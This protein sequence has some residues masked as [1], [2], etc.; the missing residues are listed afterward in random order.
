MLRDSL[1]PHARARP[2]PREHHEDDA[3]EQQG[4]DRGQ[5]T[6][7]RFFPRGRRGSGPTHRL[8]QLLR[9][10]R[11]QVRF[12]VTTPRSHLNDCHPRL[13]IGHG[14]G[15]C[16]GL[17]AEKYP[18]SQSGMSTWIDLRVAGMSV[19]WFSATPVGGAVLNTKRYR[20]AACR[21]SGSKDAVGVNGRQHR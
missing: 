1:P 17:F 13:V 20:D 7:V 16:P 8:Q 21:G 6:P 18:S 2:N 10:D 19:S 5:G 9:P 11:G 4:E 15:G 3:A 14:P 12:Y